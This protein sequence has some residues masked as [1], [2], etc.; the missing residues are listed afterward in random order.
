MICQCAKFTTNPDTDMK[1]L[2]LTC[3]DCKAKA[4]KLV[5]EGKAKNVEQA[6]VVNREEMQ[7]GLM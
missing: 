1:V 5:K 3:D 4:E 6:L 2:M 7:A